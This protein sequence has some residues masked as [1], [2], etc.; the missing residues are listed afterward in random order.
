MISMDTLLV[1][2][3]LVALFFFIG[4]FVRILREYERAVIFRLGRTTRAVLNP[5]GDGHGPGLVLLVP[6]IDKKGR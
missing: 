3:V 4:S 5:G 1:L 2:V 6:F